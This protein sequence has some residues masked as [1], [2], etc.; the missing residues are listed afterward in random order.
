MNYAERRQLFRYRG[1][2]ESVDDHPARLP[3][4]L[5]AALIECG[6]QSG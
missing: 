3:K 5:D 1:R 6:R 4:S 2:D